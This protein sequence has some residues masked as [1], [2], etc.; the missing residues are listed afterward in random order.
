MNRRT[1]VLGFTALFG[2]VFLGCSDATGGRYEVS[3][4]VTFNG[5][6]LDQGV[7]MFVGVDQDKTQASAMVTNGKYQIPKAQGLVPGKYRVAISAPDG[8]SPTDR[9]AAPGPTGNFTSKDRIPPKYN[10]ESTLEVEVK[11]GAEN[12]F[13]FTV[14]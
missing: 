14:P 1:T 6:P 4:S 13:D 11:S 10:T 7:V 2:L 12:K 3:G 5:Q 9:D 8:K